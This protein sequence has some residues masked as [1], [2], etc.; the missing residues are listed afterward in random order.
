MS[1]LGSSYYSR[2]AATGS[3]YRPPVLQSSQSGQSGQSGQ[4]SVS[5]SFLTCY[6][7]A[8]SISVFFLF[9]FDSSLSSF[10]SF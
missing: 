4:S 5:S 2:V 1:L 6:Y 3:G 8:F 9:F 10:L 7:V